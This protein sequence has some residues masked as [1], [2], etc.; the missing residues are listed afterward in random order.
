M[1]DYHLI[2]PDD[3]EENYFYDEMQAD[4]ERADKIIA[5][6]YKDAFEYL[7]AKLTN[8]FE[9]MMVEFKDKLCLRTSLNY[10]IRVAEIFS[11]DFPELLPVVKKLKE[12][13][14]TLNFYL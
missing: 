7:E 4:D 14:T 10:I 12:K 3:S 2:E 8:D 5:R 6:N 13:M 11:K 9:N 1:Q